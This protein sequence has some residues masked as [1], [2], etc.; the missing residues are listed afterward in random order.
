MAVDSWDSTWSD[1]TKRTVIA[2]SLAIHRR[3]GT[4]FAVQQIVAPF[5]I[6]VLIREWWQTG[7][8][9]YTFSLTFSSSNWVASVQQSILAAINAV[10]PV[11]AEML[12]S[13]TDGFSAD[14]NACCVLRVTRFDRLEILCQP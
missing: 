8:T 3:K 13:N 11:R 5:G 10:K 9:P 6:T 12:V 2:N 1:E 4:A 14:V 7:G